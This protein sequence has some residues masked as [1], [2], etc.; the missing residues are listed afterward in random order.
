MKALDNEFISMYQD[1]CMMH[2][3]DR[4]LGSI[5]GI[6]YIEPEPV[7]MEDIAKKTGYSLAS[8]S[9][10]VKMLE[11]IGMI[12]KMHKPGTKKI[13]LSVDKDMSKVMEGMFTKKLAA[14]NMVTS[15]IPKMLDKYKNKAKTEK[16]KKKIDLVENYYKQI[17]QFKDI[18]AKILKEFNK[19]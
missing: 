15:S 5:V 8:I 9:N 12:S 14:L 18:I 11:Q 13:Y 2:G 6:L 10:K 1:M 19:K 7:A 4:A 16:D 3:M 17:S